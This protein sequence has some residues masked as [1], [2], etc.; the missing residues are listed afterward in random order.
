MGANPNSRPAVVPGRGSTP[1]IAAEEET[2]RLARR[3]RDEAGEWD[4]WRKGTVTAITTTTL[5]DGYM[6]T[7]ADVWMTGDHRHENWEGEGQ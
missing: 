5:I 2:D 6:K 7:R 4:R 3:V 1:G